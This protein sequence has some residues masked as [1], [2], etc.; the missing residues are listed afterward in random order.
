MRGA[1]AIFDHLCKASGMLNLSHETETL[2]ARLADAQ[3]L[4]VDVAVR[5]ALEAQARGRR[6]CVGAELECAVIPT[7]QTDDSFLF[8]FPGIRTALTLV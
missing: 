7:S 8:R 4:P 2:A 3:R 1:L 6:S 5:Q